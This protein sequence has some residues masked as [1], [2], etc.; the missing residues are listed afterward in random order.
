MNTYAD[1]SFEFNEVLGNHT[2]AAQSSGQGATKLNDN[3]PASIIQKKIKEAINNNPAKQKV[4]GMPLA[5]NRPH[6]IKLMQLK[7]TMPNTNNFH[8]EGVLQGM[9]ETTV[10]QRVAVVEKYK[11]FVG[12]MNEE[13]LKKT[14]ADDTIDEADRINAKTQLKYINDKPYRRIADLVAQQ[15]FDLALILARNIAVPSAIGI[16]VLPTTNY[17]SIINGADQP[18]GIPSGVTIAGKE[19]GKSIIYIHTAN[20]EKWVTQ[21]AIGNL[22]STIVHESVHVKQNINEKADIIGA[23]VLLTPNEREFEAFSAEIFSAE[24][25]D[26]KSKQTLP[27]HAHITA[28]YIKAKEHYSLSAE[29]DNQTNRYMKMEKAYKRLGPILEENDLQLGRIDQ[30]IND[31]EGPLKKYVD[32]V[33]GALYPAHAFNEFSK[34]PDKY[35]NMYLHIEE[36]IDRAIAK[37]RKEHQTYPSSMGEASRAS[38]SASSSSSSASPH[39]SPDTSSSSSS[40]SKQSSSSASSSSSSAPKKRAPQLTRYKGIQP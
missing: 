8:E 17:E 5:D 22:I 37:N 3:R 26:K 34:I 10:I 28:S 7:S 14:M 32:G 15:K 27:T 9:F 20:I 33:K 23:Q 29:N 4:Q 13:Q 19:Y 2:A 39:L 21:G 31:I 30:I 35:R 11:C 24:G 25:L 40:L 6:S 18:S 16:T 12:E 1:R 36:L 38:T